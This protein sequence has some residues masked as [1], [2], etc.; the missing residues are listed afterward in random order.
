ML[1]TAL[2]YQSHSD[3]QSILAYSYIHNLNE[4]LHIDHHVD[5]G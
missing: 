5:K 3:V 2:T 1:V 4:A